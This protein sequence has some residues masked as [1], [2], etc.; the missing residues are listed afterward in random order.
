MISVGRVDKVWFANVNFT[1]GLMMYGGLTNY[2]LSGE[3]R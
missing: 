1:A 2:V 3:E